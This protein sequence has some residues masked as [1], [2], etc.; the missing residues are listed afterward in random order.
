MRT[1]RIE[2][3]EFCAGFLLN[4]ADEIEAQAKA[5]FEA[6]EVEAAAVALSVVNELRTQIQ[7][8]K[9]GA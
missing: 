7:I 5:G 6:G 4:A 9:E 8:R 3:S 1:I 2:I